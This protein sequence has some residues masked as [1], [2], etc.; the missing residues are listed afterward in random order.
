MATVKAEGEE[1]DSNKKQ[2]G[3]QRRSKKYQERDRSSKNQQNLEVN[4]ANNKGICNSSTREIT[5]R[6]NK[7]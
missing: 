2:Q 3:R 7:G 4:I 6:R 1:E 5:T